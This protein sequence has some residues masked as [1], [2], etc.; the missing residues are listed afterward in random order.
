MIRRT[1]SLEL[2]KRLNEPRGFMQIL[3]GP[4]QTGKTTATQQA[5][6]SL[7]L[8]YHY[9]SADD[10]LRASPEWLRS[11]WELA[12]LKQ[13]ASSSEF[14]LVFD[15]IQ[16]IDSWSN[17][18]KQYYDEDSFSNTPIKVVLTGSSSLLLMQGSS[19]SLMGRFELLHS[20]QW[21]YSECVKAFDFSL[22]DYLFFGGYPGAARF[23]NDI[24]RWRDYLR[25]SIVEPSISIDVANMAEIR[26]PALM[27]ALFELGTHYSGQ[28]LSFT[29]MLGQLHDAG[30]TVTLAHYLN[31]LGNAGLLSGL[32]KYASTQIAKRK[33]SPR[34]M[35]HDSS[36]MTYMSE[37][38][39][40]TLIDDHVFRGHIVESAVGAY[41][42]AR[43]KQEDF[44][45]FWWREGTSEVDFILQKGDS[46]TAIEVKSG[47]PK[48]LGGY[49]DF[50][51]KHPSALGYTVG[52]P[53]VS[54]EDFL[55]GRYPLFK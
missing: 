20:T 4:R 29:K 2:Q 5:I 37:I 54:I 50:L 9:V 42:L 21:S 10:P 6:E 34:F 30:N 26:K 33:S 28:E 43:S 41:L 19:E 18:V 14:I 27:R 11:E 40:Q 25:Y 53:Q 48:K 47:R 45:V 15:E 55:L 7:S 35:V 12:R 3:I 22:E 16:K 17:V 8:P 49:L 44:K 32:Q 24:D 52:T 13:K 46:V 23:K 31:L 36:F 1:I 51:K 38:T 39:P